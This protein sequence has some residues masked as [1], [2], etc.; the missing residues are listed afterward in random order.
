M[1]GANKGYFGYVDDTNDDYV[2]VFKPYFKGSQL[3]I[4]VIAF[5]PCE[6]RIEINSQYKIQHGFRVQVF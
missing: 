6:K 2:R 4:K 1:N 3:M 5:S